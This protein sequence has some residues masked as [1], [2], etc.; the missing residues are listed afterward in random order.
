MFDGQT[1]KFEVKTYN[2]IEIIFE[3][4]TGYF[5][6]SQMCSSNDKSWRDYKRTKMYQ[7]KLAAFVK[8]LGAGIPAPSMIAKNGVIPR[9]QGEYLHPKLIHFVA[10]Y[11]S[12]EYAFK[13]AELMDSINDQVHKQLEEKKLDDKP[14][15]SQKLFI[16]TCETIISLIDDANKRGQQAFEQQFA[17]G[18]HDINEKGNEMI[19][20][21]NAV[22]DL[23]KHRETMKTNLHPLYESVEQYRLNELKK[24]KNKPKTQHTSHM[25][26]LLE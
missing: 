6:A 19:I 20:I 12:D 25:L 14:D 11:I 26:Q 2:G 13:V 17:Y 9:F 8:I 10:E 22:H 7:R 23:L 4:N 1:C 3:I 5:N 15:N 16:S 21:N 18:I 24:Y